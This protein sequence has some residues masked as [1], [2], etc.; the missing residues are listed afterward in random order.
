MKQ[1]LEQL[2]ELE[3]NSNLGQVVHRKFS[4]TRSLGGQLVTGLTIL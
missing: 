1:L 4:L 2:Y 3:N